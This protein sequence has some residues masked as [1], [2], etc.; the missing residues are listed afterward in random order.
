MPNERV[1]N[2][3]PADAESLVARVYLLCELADAATRL[4]PALDVGDMHNAEFELSNL[5]G[6]CDERA[7][8]NAHKGRMNKPRPRGAISR[9]RL[10]CWVGYRGG[11]AAAS[12]RPSA[13]HFGS[14]FG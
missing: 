8:W 3:L 10:V 12:A 11:A 13:A 4:V 6:L 9:V 14:F 2:D 1:D 7:D 5:R